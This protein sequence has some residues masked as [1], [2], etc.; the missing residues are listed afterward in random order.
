MSSSRRAGG[1]NG[2]DGAD[3]RGSLKPSEMRKQRSWGPGVQ[4]NE[5][6]WGSCDSY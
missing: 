3:S 2:G 6:F 4:R 1:E 5:H